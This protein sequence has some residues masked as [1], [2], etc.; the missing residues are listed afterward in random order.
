MIEVYRAVLA[1]PDV[2]PGMVAAI[3][4]FGELLHFHPHLHALVS[5]GAFA[6][7]GTFIGLPEL[8]SQPFEKLWQRKVFDLL[9]KRGKIDEPLV[10]QTLGWQHSGFSVNFAVRLGPHDTAG[11]ERLAQYMLR[12]PFSLQRMIRVTSEGKVLYRAEKRVPRRFPQPG[13]QTLLAGVA[14]NFQ[15]F[16]PLGG[17]DQA[18]L[19]HRSVG[20]PPLWPSHAH[21]RLRPARPAPRDR[22]DP[23][24]LR[25]L[26]AALPR[27]APRPRRGAA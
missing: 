21:R 18:G 20:V 11:R 25:P 27:A 14:R 26:G 1:W 8:D 9:L 23:A 24:T 16:D 10:T 4:T 3:H 22:K 13:A 6:P 7:D 2:T 17:A 5:D 19:A 12:C 15:V